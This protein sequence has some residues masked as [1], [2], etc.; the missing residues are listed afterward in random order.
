MIQWVS[1]FIVFFRILKQSHA[2]D[3]YWYF[4]IKIHSESTCSR[5]GISIETG[6]SNRGKLHPKYECTSFQIQWFD[7]HPESLR[8]IW[9]KP[10]GNRISLLM[11][12]SF[13][14]SISVRRSSE[15]ISNVFLTLLG[16]RNVVTYL[17]Q[18]KT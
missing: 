16:F 15:S 18:K 10:D 7:P 8:P 11:R 1:L 17:K 6:K 12:H 5:L 13:M 9:G 3:Y 2:K 4:I 14:Q